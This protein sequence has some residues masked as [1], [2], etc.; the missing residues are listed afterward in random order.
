MIQYFYLSFLWIIWCFL[1]SFF[2]ALSFVQKIEHKLG[3]SFRYYRLL[4]NL[5]AF[6]SLIPVYLYTRSLYTE[7]FWIWTGKLL[8]VKYFLVFTGFVLLW[9]GSKSFSMKQFTGISQALK[10]NSFRTLNKKGDISSNGVLKFIRHPWYT[11]G[12]V[13]IWSQNFDITRL[14]VAI[15]LTIYIVI[16]AFLEEQKLLRE[17]GD[18]YKNY[19]ESVSMF[20]PVKWFRKKFN[21]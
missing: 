9:L 19:R 11:S 16:G 8:I 3:D 13:L 10:S 4:Y 12:I 6:I 7:P 21:F 5:F 18:S 20:F 17:F 1:H 14:I 2:I 15:I